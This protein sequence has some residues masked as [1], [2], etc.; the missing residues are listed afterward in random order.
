MN[1]DMK[2]RNEKSIHID[3]F[4]YLTGNISDYIIHVP[5][6]DTRHVAPCGA[7]GKS[8]PNIRHV[9][10]G[11][12]GNEHVVTVVFEDGSH[13]TKRCLPEDKYDLNVGVAL[14]IADRVY[15]T[16]SRF[17]KEVLRRKVVNR[18]VRKKKKPFRN[19]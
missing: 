11:M 19:D 14:C 8:I 6:N 13:V 17:H 16:V 5:T 4:K 3:N 10:E 15:G 9:V 12:R 18:P 2:N 1:K 7:Q